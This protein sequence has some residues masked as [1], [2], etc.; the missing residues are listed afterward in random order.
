M[1]KKLKEMG[2]EEL[3]EHLQSDVKKVLKMLG[4]LINEGLQEAPDELLRQG[5]AFI[6]VHGGLSALEAKWLAMHG[7]PSELNDILEQATG[8]SKK[9]DKKYFN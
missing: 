1:S 8:D 6:I 7:M 2:T 3:R 4:N 5:D 9:D